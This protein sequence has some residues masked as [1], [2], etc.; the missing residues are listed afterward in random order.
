VL[1]S[2]RP[3]G[4][5]PNAIAVPTRAATASRGVPVRPAMEVVATGTAAPP[6]AKATVPPGAATM[7]VEWLAPKGSAVAA[8]ASASRVF[9]LRLPGGRPRLRGTNG[10]AAG[11]L[12]LLRLPNGRPRLRPP[13]PLEAPALAP[14]K[15]SSNDIEVREAE[16]MGW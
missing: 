13:S 5:A 10:V 2:A 4:A 6:A 11:S 16:T 7:A 3:R 15:A 12:A 8:A 9:L 14:L 1:K